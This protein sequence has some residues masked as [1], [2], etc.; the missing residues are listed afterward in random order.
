MMIDLN[1]VRVRGNSIWGRHLYIKIKE[2]P[3]RFDFKEIMIDKMLS[4]RNVDDLPPMLQQMDK[5]VT[6]NGMK[7]SNE[8]LIEISLIG[9]LFKRQLIR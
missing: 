4:N 9:S 7:I 3:I 8:N 5:S 2:F 6:K 1:N